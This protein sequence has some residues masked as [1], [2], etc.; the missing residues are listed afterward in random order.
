[1]SVSKALLSSREGI[2]SLFNLV[3]SKIGEESNKISLSGDDVFKMLL[4]IM[5]AQL[6]IMDHLIATS[7]NES[8]FSSELAKITTATPSSATTTCKYL[9]C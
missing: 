5:Q 3:N 8:N 2:Q 4:P 9:T 7:G 6:S 1:M